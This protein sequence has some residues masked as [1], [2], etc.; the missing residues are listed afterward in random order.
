[1]RYQAFLDVES[2]DQ[3]LPGVEVEMK[4]GLMALL[5]TLFIDVLG[6]STLL[7]FFGC[8]SYIWIPG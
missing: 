4:N 7:S 1:M 3:I 8:L 2:F 6:I 5:S